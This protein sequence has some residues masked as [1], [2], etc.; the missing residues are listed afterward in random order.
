MRK[1]TGTFGSGSLP[2]KNSNDLQRWAINTL[3]NHAVPCNDA[4]EILREL[5][6]VVSFAYVGRKHTLE[7]T[8][9]GRPVNGPANLL[10]VDVADLLSKYGIRGNWLDTSWA[11]NTGLVAELEAIAQT[12]LRQ[13]CRE[14]NGVAARPARISRARKTLGKVHRN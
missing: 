1:W 10:S 13:A 4:K 6:D 7:Q 14:A 5:I 11:G 9:A 2:D 8:G 12:V 3:N